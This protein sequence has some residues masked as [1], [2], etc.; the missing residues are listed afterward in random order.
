MAS[1]RNKPCP[2][3]SGQKYKNCHLNRSTEP[4]KP[5]N[6][7]LT[8]FRGAKSHKICLHPD[9][10][11]TA[12]S[13]KIIGAHSIQRKR[14]LERIARDGKVY[15]SSS[16]LI[17]IEKGE[18]R[19]QFKLSHIKSA[20]TFNG[21][22]GKHDAE[23]FLP[24]ETRPLTFSPEQCFLLGYRAMCL[25][26]H[27]KMGV[28]RILKT[29]SHLDAGMPLEMQIAFQ[30]EFASRSKFTMQGL[31]DVQYCKRE[32]DIALRAR[33]YS[34]IDYYVVEFDSLPEVMCSG[35]KTPTVD[36]AGQA[37]QSLELSNA[38]VDSITLNIV[39]TEHGGAAVFTW[40]KKQGV[41]AAEKFVQSLVR[42]PDGAKAQAI[43]R[44]A[45]TIENSFFSP[46][47]WE[48]LSS[49]SRERLGDRLQQAA[50]VY[51]PFPSQVDDR[52]RDVNW[53]ITRCHTSLNQTT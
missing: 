18:G 8:E 27:S 50:D 34:R 13:E 41:S 49:E 40:L 29:M 30:K 9:S 43:V 47:W 14:L 25:E 2:C 37:I 38:N 15:G 35:A 33:D 1:N 11:T 45:L 6:D 4:R 39:A 32:L 26:L 17:D 51:R 23:V 5:L 36:I 53:N 46:E 22:C 7:L 21:F 42:L 20:S 19:V 44:V 10:S 12:C 52:H 16:D 48:G 24:I 3:G 31:E 28:A